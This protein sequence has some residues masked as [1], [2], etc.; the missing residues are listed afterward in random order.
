MICLT[1]DKLIKLADINVDV[2]TDECKKLT[3]VVKSLDKL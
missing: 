2:L 3:Q 1:F